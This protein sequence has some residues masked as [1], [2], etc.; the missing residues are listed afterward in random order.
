MLIGEF[1]HTIDI[2]KRL[3][4]PAKFRKEL[5]KIV[6]ITR[7]LDNCLFIYPQKEWQ[8]LAEKL[9]KLPLG[10]SQTRN[11]TR[12]MLSGA[13]EV[14]IDSLGRILVPD[15]LKQYSLIEKEVIIVGLYNRLE[16]W[17]KKQWD[18]YKS[19]VEKDTNNLAERLGD[20]GAF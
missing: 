8:V 7:G 2:K 16:V 4:L 3:S 18:V 15:Y 11:F 5:G 1:L 20:L 6:V 9:S 10:Q 14:E 19:K 13:S 12:L 17:D